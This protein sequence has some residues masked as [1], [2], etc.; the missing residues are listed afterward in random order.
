MTVKELIERYG[1]CNQITF[2]KARARKDAH[3][4]FCHS[5]YQTTPILR[6]DELKTLLDYIVL[7]D[8][9][10]PIDWLSGARWGVHFHGGELECW[11]VI[12]PEDFK[13]LYPSDDQRS[14]MIRYID[15]RIIRRRGKK[16]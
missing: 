13:T 2:I 1:I 4:P 15:D 5:E 10:A 7:N 16:E 9:Q 6:V 11:L 8:H 3:S 12:S 14:G